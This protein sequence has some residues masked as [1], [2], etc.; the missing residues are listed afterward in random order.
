V[1]G[2]EIALE[3]SNLVLLV[4]GAAIWNNTGDCA[5]LRNSSGTLVDEYC[6]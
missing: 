2:W 4:G 5:Y 6:Y 1:D 3:I